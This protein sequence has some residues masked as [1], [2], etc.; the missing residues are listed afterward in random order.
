MN[1]RISLQF[2]EVTLHRDTPAWA[3]L[4]PQPGSQIGD[5]IQIVGPGTVR[6]PPIDDESEFAY[7]VGW[8]DCRAVFRSNT[9]LLRR[10]DRAAITVPFPIM[11]NDA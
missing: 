10:G 6:F 9:I 11:M 8:R 4:G 5:A 3:D 2:D 7:M 1:P